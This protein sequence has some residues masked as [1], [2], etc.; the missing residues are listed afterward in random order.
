LDRPASN[1]QW[2]P[3]SPHGSTIAVIPLSD[4]HRWLKLD[5]AMIDI[6]DS[7]ERVV[8]GT[9]ARNVAGKREV[10]RNAGIISV[11]A[12]VGGVISHPRIHSAALRV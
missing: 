12:I 7:Q 1:R 6:L 9:T 4:R 5:E 3:H 8:D 2:T 10:Y 11:E